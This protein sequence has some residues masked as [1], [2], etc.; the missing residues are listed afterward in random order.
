[1][2]EGEKTN[3]TSFYNELDTEHNSLE[4]HNDNPSG[5]GLV[6]SEENEHQDENWEI[7][8]PQH[9]I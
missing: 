7:D 3:I 2:I 6:Q 5:E 1:V 4:A 8:I 9:L